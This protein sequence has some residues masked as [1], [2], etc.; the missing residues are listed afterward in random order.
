MAAGSTDAEAR[1]RAASDAVLEAIS[2]GFFA[3]DRAW[4]FVA[5]NAA[6]ER[7][8]VL[9]RAEV[10][11]R[12][13]WE[14]SPTIAGTQ[15]EQRYRSVMAGGPPQVFEME[16]ALRPG[17]FHE[18][19][20]FGLSEGI[21]IVFRD[22]SER[23]AAEAHQALL[24]HELNH[25]VKNTLAVVQAVAAQSFRAGLTMEAARAAFDGRL[26]ALARVHDVLTD[27]A[28]E[29]ASLREVVERALAPYRG[30]P[31]RFRVEGDGVRLTSGTAI[32][33]SLA[34][35]EL[36]TNAIK[37]GAL[38]A[39]GGTVAIAWTVE[40]SGARRRLA[41][42]WEERGGPP[43]VPPTRRGFGTRLIERSFPR[44]ADGAA[45]LVFAPEGLRCRIVTALPPS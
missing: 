2:D 24:L 18:I 22:I 15:F 23:K 17:R 19:R 31:D 1:A 35:Q 7:F 8:F 37:Y 39:A 29:G 41:F 5:F 38:A 10:L 20:A 42:G 44:D 4:R 13:I 34:L 43:V 26:A 27:E 21:A 45:D 9:P 40:P 14:V 3:L 6:A 25:R 16:S 33:F 12:T 32:A 36:A 30:E 11:G 28:W